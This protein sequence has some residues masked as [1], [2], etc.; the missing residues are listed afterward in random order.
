VTSNIDADR[1][2]E[3]VAEPNGLLDAGT[4]TPRPSPSRRR[5][6]RRVIVPRERDLL[7][8]AI[9]QPQLV[10]DWLDEMLFQDPTARAAYHQLAN[11]PSFADALA[12]SDADV[13]VLLERLAV[14]EPED[15]DEPET[16]RA[17]LLTVAVEPIAQRT[18]DVLA[19]RD[20]ISAEASK[21]LDELQNARMGDWERAEEAARRLLQWLVLERGGAAL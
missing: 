5:R 14:E 2:R 20:E 3:E 18:I 6:E 12:G 1:L 11:T 16:L 15:D 8:W 13:R 10:A 17:R 19:E 9:H 4:A 21:D 7:R